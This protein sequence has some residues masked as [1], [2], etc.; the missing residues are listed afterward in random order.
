MKV[1]IQDVAGN[2]FDPTAGQD[3]MRMLKLLNR[4]LDTIHSLVLLSLPDCN[5]LSSNSS[6]SSDSSYVPSENCSD[7]YSDDVEK[8]KKYKLEESSR[9]TGSHPPEGISSAALV[10]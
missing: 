1:V 6:D 3:V 10:V 8:P 2:M 4:K 7:E 5:E 9:P